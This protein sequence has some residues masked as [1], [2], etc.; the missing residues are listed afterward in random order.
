MLYTVQQHEK[1]KR[2]QA[3]ISG[4]FEWSPQWPAGGPGQVTR[5]LHK[6][7]QGQIMVYFIWSSIMRLLRRLGLTFFFHVVTEFGLGGR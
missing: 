6:L 5:L 3:D 2:T 7:I 4:L 1:K